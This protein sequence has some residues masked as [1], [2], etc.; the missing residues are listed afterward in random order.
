MS[1]PPPR[2]DTFAFPGWRVED[3]DL[4]AAHFFATHA[5]QAVPLAGWL[6]A[7]A[8][9]PPAARGVLWLAAGAYTAWVAWLAYCAFV[10]ADL[11]T[12]LR[13]PF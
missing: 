9:P 7:A 8:L 12:I 13:M 1:N 11:P 4:R 5:M 10:G 2:G 3:G 6:S